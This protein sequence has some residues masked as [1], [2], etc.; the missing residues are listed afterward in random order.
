MRTISSAW[1]SASSVAAELNIEIAIAFRR[2]SRS[3]TR[4][5]TAAATTF[6]AP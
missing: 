6:P 1:E 3:A 4:P 2:P 5:P